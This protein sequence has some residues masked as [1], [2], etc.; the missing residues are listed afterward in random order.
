M[1]REEYKKRANFLKK[2]VTV[3]L[4]DKDLYGIAEDI[5]ENGALKL[6]DKNNNEHILL[7]G[8][9]L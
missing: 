6:L 3:R 7:I 5:T 2:E 9:I 8:D 1:I 4:P